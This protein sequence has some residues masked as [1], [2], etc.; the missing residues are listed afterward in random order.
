VRGKVRSFELDEP[1]VSQA[2]RRSAQQEAQAL[3]ELAAS[4]AS[5]PTGSVVLMVGGL[6][7]SGKSTLAMTLKHELGWE[8]ISSDVTRKRL[9]TGRS[10]EEINMASAPFGAGAYGKR[11]TNRT[12]AALVR[13]A[14]SRVDKGRSVVLDATWSSRSHRQHVT[15]MARQLGARPVFVECVC[16]PEIALERLAQRQQA[17]LSGVLGPDAPSVASDGRPELY[18]AQAASWQRYECDTEFPLEYLT[19]DATQRVA[20]LLEQILSTLE[21]PRLA[22]WLSPSLAPLS[23]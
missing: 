23:Q 3:F 22:C 4:Y 8:V 17:R 7:G 18:D 16:P 9:L 6:M 2:E 12:Y 1:E 10:A 5:G 21:A 15:K 14:R 20:M 19:L 13:A 11:W